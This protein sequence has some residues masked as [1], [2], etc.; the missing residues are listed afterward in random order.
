MIWLT[1]RQFRS[2]A[3]IGLGALLLL[4]VYL[5]HLGLRI[6]GDYHDALAHCPVRLGCGGQLATFADHYRLPV[7]LL[8]YLLLV[9][10]GVI[11]VF[12]G[13]PLIARELE[14]GTHRLVWN[15]SVTRS[16]W[17]A[18][19]LGLVGLA[20]VA[21]TGLLSLLLTWA[22]APVG[23]VLN[24]RF[25][26]VL[27]DSRDIAP[28]GYAAFAFAL[29]AALGLFV[30]RTVPAMGATLVVFAVLQVVVPTV[31]RPQY[32]A[33]VRTS[34]PLT[35]Q[36]ISGLTMIGAYGDIEGVH[37]SGGPWVVRTS[38]VLDSA[39]RPV[40]HTAWYQRCMNDASMAELPT[41]LADG[42]VHVDVS[43]QPA[44]RFW[45]FQWLET[46]LFTALAALLTAAT[47][48]RIRARLS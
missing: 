41:C 47:F 45:T 35:A 40:G 16:R 29:G 27:F 4:A 9:V 6:H 8:G 23:T 37:P 33:P 21:A 30:R 22:A 17:L 39:G 34:V 48:H 46:A 36:L 2:Q 5:V 31:V 28:L 26:P 1:W 15:Q 10:P 13:A 12:W 43:E 24:N 7:D 18:A 20:G 32:Q 38:A 44:D 11:G 14:A 19:K 25:S 3:L 42:H